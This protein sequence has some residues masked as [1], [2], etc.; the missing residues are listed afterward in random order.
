[1]N[2]KPFKSWHNKENKISYCQSSSTSTV[3]KIWMNHDQNPTKIQLL[4]LSTV[5]RL[6][7][8]LC[9]DLQVTKN[10]WWRLHS[11]DHLTF[12]MWLLKEITVIGTSYTLDMLLGNIIT[13]KLF[14]ISNS[15]PCHTPLQKYLAFWCSTAGNILSL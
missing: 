4:S 9:E 3:T 2:F 14:I 15:F 10:L 11:H 6:S 8:L 12:T 1:M 5:W 7:V 13:L